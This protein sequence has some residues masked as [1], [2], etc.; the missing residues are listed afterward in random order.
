MARIIVRARLIVLLLL[1]ACDRSVNPDRTAN[2]DTT[3]ALPAAL[4]TQVDSVD[5][6]IKAAELLV[7]V[8]AADTT[9]G[10]PWRDSEVVAALLTGDSLEVE[11]GKMGA[12]SGT[13]PAVKDFAQVLQT[14]HAK[15]KGEVQDLMKRAGLQPRSPE[16]DASAAHGQ[17][18][19]AA[20]Q[21]AKPHDFD[22]LFAH[23]NVRAHAHM[24]ANMRAAAGGVSS[25]DLKNHLQNA[26]IPAMHRHLE[27]ASQ[28][29]MAL[30]LAAMG[31]P[32]T[33]GTSGAPR[34]ADTAGARA[35][36][37]RR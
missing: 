1:T 29:T 6:T 13:D 7:G 3:K 9:P 34:T 5:A 35:P 22:T 10:A 24:L 16:G 30:Q 15:D 17:K 25:P 11:M 28:I 33:T 32:G 31:A 4:R 18:V 8:Q 19:A 20:L 36:S 26:V 23:E 14:D 12:A 21:A 37:G 27:R 2:P